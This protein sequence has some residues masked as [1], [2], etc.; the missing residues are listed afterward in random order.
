MRSFLHQLP[1]ELQEKRNEKNV[2]LLDKSASTAREG[3]TNISGNKVFLEGDQDKYMILNGG[4][5]LH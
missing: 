5:Q 3:G 1:L 2:A 4:S